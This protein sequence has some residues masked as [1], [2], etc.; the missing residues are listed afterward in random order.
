MTGVTSVAALYFKGL[1]AHTVFV[2]SVTGVTE[3]AKRFILAQISGL[4]GQPSRFSLSYNSTRTMCRAAV[5][6][7]G[8]RAAI[9]ERWYGW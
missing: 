4:L 5:P 3:T 9:S 1:D 7:S 8:T 6:A 2:T